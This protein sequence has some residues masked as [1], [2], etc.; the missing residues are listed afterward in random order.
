MRDIVSRA[1]KLLILCGPTGVGKSKLALELALAINAEIVSA[2]AGQVYK[3]FDIGTAK[4]LPA[5]QAHVPHYC[6]DLWA[7]DVRGD[8]MIWQRA[9]DE[10]I[11]A[12]HQRGKRVLVVG[13]TAFYIKA[14]LRGLFGGPDP[15]P[16]RRE[17]L[18]QEFEQQG[19]AVL[20][21]RLK[22]VD[23]E[24][25]QRIH[26]N[27][28][29]RLVRALEVYEQTG[30]P[31]SDLQ[32]AHQ[33]QENRYEY[34]MIGLHREREELYG[35]VNERVKQMVTAGWREEAQRLF[36]E[37]GGEV[38]AFQLI[39]YREWREFFAG[40]RS[41]ET[42]I[43]AIQQASRHYAKRQMTWLRGEAAI[44]WIRADEASAKVLKTV[45]F[46]DESTS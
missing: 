3:D 12:I 25:A 9:A 20:H 34:V 26:P 17:R 8:A 15:E 45:S 29:V 14:L 4:P 13:G 41:L 19:G 38:P 24:A 44:T 32:K 18:Q 30:T 37:W 28:S 27:D 5:E 36:E 39:G 7:A 2:D 21:A 10:A 31:I 42:V 40:E 33:F 23:S 11:R 22:E 6:I 43:P 35:R 46:G 16:E 1:E